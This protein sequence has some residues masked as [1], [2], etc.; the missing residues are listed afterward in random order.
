MNREEEKLMAM[1]KGGVTSEEEREDSAA[2]MGAAGIG[3]AGETT[4]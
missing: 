1:E 2:P 3:R 4:T